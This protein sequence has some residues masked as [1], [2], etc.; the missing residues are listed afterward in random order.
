[1]NRSNPVPSLPKNL[2]KPPVAFD[3]PLRRTLPVDAAMPPATL[4]AVNDETEHVATPLVAPP[5]DERATEGTAI[6]PRITVRIDEATRRALE[7]VCYQRRVAGEK[8]NLAEIA[9]GVLKAWA[10]SNS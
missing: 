6:P 5:S 1:V 10:D 7:T 2:V 3:N 8:T 4:H 9:R